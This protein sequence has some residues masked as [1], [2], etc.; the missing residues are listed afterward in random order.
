MGASD[1]TRSKFNS[2]STIFDEKNPPIYL[3]TYL[4]EGKPAVPLYLSAMINWVDLCDYLRHDQKGAI[5]EFRFWRLDISTA[6]SFR[7]FL[8]LMKKS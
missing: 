8:S 7:D 5:S 2:I 3:V 4:I 1:F 6:Y